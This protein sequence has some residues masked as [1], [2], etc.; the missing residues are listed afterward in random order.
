MAAS[1]SQHARN[2]EIDLGMASLH[3][4]AAS[5]DTLQSLLKEWDIR[6]DESE[7]EIQ[8]EVYHLL[9]DL[10]SLS[11]IKGIVMH[12][13]MEKRGPSRVLATRIVNFAQQTFKDFTR[14]VNEVK[15]LVENVTRVV[16]HVRTPLGGE[17]SKQKL[18]EAIKG[19]QNYIGDALDPMRTVAAPDGCYTFVDSGQMIVLRRTCNIA[20]LAFAIDSWPSLSPEEKA[21][22]L[23][24]ES[25]KK[26]K[27]KKA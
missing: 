24:P 6:E 20:E 1:V 23:L 17:G 18:E 3:T 15:R 5:A 25:Q 11:P 10:D 12:M 4:A 19:L 22:Y 7:G 27:E 9:K 16:V 13:L 21:A 8:K 26:E 14:H 2:P